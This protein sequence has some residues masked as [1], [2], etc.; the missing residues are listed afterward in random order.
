MTGKSG[1]K[2]MEYRRLYEIG[3]DNLINADI[4]DAVLDAR[5]LLEFICHTDRNYLYAHGDEDVSPFLEEMY[6]QAIKKRAEHIPLQHITGRQ[7][8]MGLDFIVNEHVLIPRQDTET[9]VEEA[10]LCCN[11][12]DSLLDLCTGSGCVLISVARY[13]NDLRTVGVDISEEAIEVARKNADRLLEGD[14]YNKPELVISDLYKEIKGRFDIIT[15]NPPY[16]K[17]GVIEGLTPEVKDHDPM[18]ALDGGEDGLILI[19]R[20][21]EGA[22][23]YLKPNGSLLM[24]IGHDQGEEVRDIYLAN[25]FLDVEVVKDLCGNDRVVK[26][27]I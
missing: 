21:V 11:D 8:F 15:S 6:L 23:D 22:K 20:I 16:I 2:K 24:E 10:M 25:G 14:N 26:G 18:L 17:T 4:A 27:R 1:R 12:G 13:K 5:L 9:L 3:K 7:E 19:R